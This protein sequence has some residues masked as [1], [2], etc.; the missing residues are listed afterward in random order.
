M[1]LASNGIRLHKPTMRKISQKVIELISSNYYLLGDIFLY[2]IIE[3]LLSK[4]W[5]NSQ[6]PT[7][8]Q[9]GQASRLL[10]GC[11]SFEMTNINS[12]VPNTK[13]EQRKLNTADND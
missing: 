2:D 11:E 13:Q 4:N 7:I 10:K 5:G 1:A 6:F 9:N 3:H 12:N 8:Q